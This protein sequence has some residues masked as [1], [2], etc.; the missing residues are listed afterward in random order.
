M[1]EHPSAVV[2]ELC[3]SSVI[4]AH[5]MSAACDGTPVVLKG[6]GARRR[7]RFD[8]ADGFAEIAFLDQGPD[9]ARMGV[10]CGELMAEYYAREQLLHR[11]RTCIIGQTAADRY[12]L[13]RPHRIAT[14]ERRGVARRRVSGESACV[15]ELDLAGNR[16][17]LEVIDLSCQGACLWLSSAVRS[18]LDNRRGSGW[19]RVVGN[20]PIPMEFE[21]RHGGAAE[22]DPGVVGVSFTHIRSADRRRL[23]S[24][25]ADLGGEEATESLHGLCSVDMGK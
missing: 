10:F 17:M 14:S 16:S 4:D 5:L 6:T 13:R 20:T 2:V 22:Q 19:L 23:R 12:R 18:A 21:V 1:S 11:F 15:F 3:G 9:R 7:G 24:I 8:L 25:L